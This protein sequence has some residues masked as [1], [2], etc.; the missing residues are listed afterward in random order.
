MIILVPIFEPW[1]SSLAMHIVGQAP[2]KE[3][4]TKQ[5]MQA[6]MILLSTID[7]KISGANRRNIDENKALL[8]FEIND[9][10]S[11]FERRVLMMSASTFILNC[12]ISLLNGSWLK[13]LIKTGKI[14]LLIQNI[15]R[16]GLFNNLLRFY[17]KIRPRNERN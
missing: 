14:L 2:L 9:F 17:T 13:K 7:N 3:L 16:C 6:A 8:R 5:A 12:P 4:V 15:L 10:K 11:G 1:S